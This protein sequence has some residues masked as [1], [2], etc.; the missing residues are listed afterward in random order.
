MEKHPAFDATAGSV[1]TADSAHMT[2]ILTRKLEVFA[3]KGLPRTGSVQQIAKEPGLLKFGTFSPHTFHL[4]KKVK[5][6]AAE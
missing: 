4:G 6:F 5:V 2:F 1:H 3:A